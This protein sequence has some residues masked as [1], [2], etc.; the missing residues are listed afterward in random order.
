MKKLIL[1]G[2]ITLITFTHA[3]MIDGIALIVEGE[4]VT[5]AEIRAVT[6]QLGVSK[7][8]ATDLLI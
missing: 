7:E 1:L 8:K 3:K 6:Q 4:A 2:F 5:T